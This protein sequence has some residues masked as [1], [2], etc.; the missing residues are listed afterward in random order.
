MRSHHVKPRPWV[1]LAAIAS[2]VL[3][4]AGIAF[5]Q[6][7]YD[8]RPGMRQISVPDPT[9]YLTI[10]SF[11]A[12]VEGPF[13]TN[14]EIGWSP[15]G[16]FGLTIGPKLGA[17]AGRQIL[18]PFVSATIG[19]SDHPHYH[20]LAMP[21]I[22][23]DD[24]GAAGPNAPVFWEF[25]RNTAQLDHTSVTTPQNL[26]FFQTK[27]WLVFGSPPRYIEGEWQIPVDDTSNLSATQFVMVRERYTVLRDTMKLELFITNDTNRTGAGIPLAIGVRVFY[28]PT[29][30]STFND[31][32][33]IFLSSGGSP[34][35]TEM[36][37]DNDP[38][39][40]APPIPESWTTFETGSAVG[41]N[42]VSIKG[43]I[44]GQDI[45]E[46]MGANESAGPPD[47][48]S[49]GRTGAMNAPF[50]FFFTP[51]NVPLQ[52]FDWATDIRWDIPDGPDLEPGRTRRYATYIGLGNA[53]SDFRE[54]YVL[55]M[56]GPLVLD[57]AQGDDPSTPTVETFFY[58]VDANDPAATGVIPIRC[59]ANNFGAV[60][61]LNV[62]LTV[63][64]PIGAPLEFVDAS[65]NPF[66]PPPTSRTIG[67]GNVLPNTEGAASFFIRAKPGGRPGVYT[68][69]CSGPGGKTVE[70]PITVPAVPSLAQDTLD[71]VDAITMI[72]VPFQ[73]QNPDAENVLQ[74]LGPLGSSN[75]SIARW[76][77]TANRY[78]FFPDPFT[79]QILPGQGFWLINRAL[80]RIDLPDEPDRQDV[81]VAAG[82]LVP[83][84]R[85][86]NQ[87]GNVFRSTTFWST[88]DFLV[89]GQVVDFSRAVSDR[90]VLP[91][92]FAYDEALGDYTF[93]TDINAVRMDPWRAYWVFVTTDLSAIINPPQVAVGRSFRAPVP[94]VGPRATGP[95]H[96]TAELQA[97]VGGLRASGRRFGIEAEA[98]DGFGLEDI[99]SPPCAYSPDGRLDVCF[100]HEDWGEMSGRYRYDIRSATAAEQAWDVLV[101]TD[102]PNEAV[103]VSWPDLTSVPREYALTLRDLDVNRVVSMRTQAS[104]AFNS[105][106]Q[107]GARRLRITA[108]PASQTALRLENVRL[109]RV[110]GAGARLLFSINADA[111]VDA[112]LTNIAGRRVRTLAKSRAV[113]S[114]ENAILWDGRNDQG[115][116]LP[117]GVYMLN[118]VARSERDRVRVVQ[119]F[120]NVR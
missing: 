42:Q 86:W 18:G 97:S 94:R 58:T 90:L 49:F 44:A 107:G 36:Q 9:G 1:R 109:E 75:A 27:S 19:A 53:T 78:R 55:A 85:G 61:L 37:F 117:G 30:G 65:G 100:V 5:S 68:L 40:P 110:R 52:G 71:P 31:A 119:Q 3:V 45:N 96:W 64:L 114:G 111:V 51:L 66:V 69:R 92:L 118:L 104:Y 32:Q 46:T 22:A 4:M 80:T 7:D 8:H 112:E 79:T 28:D 35:T 23:V 62:N 108:R 84:Q 87:I 38:T 116:M 63:S 93:E 50:Q 82:F 76:D 12:Y 34:V 67:V 77:P 59:F 74:S 13:G 83:L 91:T 73:F 72:S 81:S 105:G 115:A 48:L 57:V 106:P 29:F 56:E 99:M 20:Y 89:Q 103:V 2:A 17:L 54:P 15:G 70:R 60:T 21:I 25:H 6:A 102:L 43:T 10:N 39:T 14:N 16:R 88:T 11:Q 47:V 101:E 41:T 98:S 26:D 95:V 33:P 24:D 120:V 113:A